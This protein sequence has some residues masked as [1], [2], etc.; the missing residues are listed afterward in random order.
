[1]VPPQD[2]PV[3]KKLIVWN[4]GAS[5]QR[6]GNRASMETSSGMRTTRPLEPERIEAYV[7][8]LRGENYFYD[9]Q[10]HRRLFSLPLYL[11]RELA[12]GGDVFA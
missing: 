7:G 12:K 8:E 11:R 10:T 1:M 6:C 5:L 9:A 4:A 2:I 3:A